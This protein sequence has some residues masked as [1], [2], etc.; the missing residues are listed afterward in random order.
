MI[1]QECGNKPAAL[2]F[3]KIVNGEKT[4]FHLC[5]SCAREKGDSIPGAPNG[6]SIH[7]LLSGI[8]EFEPS[9]GQ[10]V[11]QQKKVIRC[12]NCGLTYSQFRKIGRFGCSSCY[13]HF[14][15]PLNPLLKRV[16]GNS[17]HVGKIPK[18]SGGKIKYKRQIKDLKKELQSKID[19]EEFEEAAKLRDEIRSLE[20]KIS[21][22]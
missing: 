1:C 2:H 9:M 17:V 19:L 3:T 18:I 6:F 12:E 7:N 4:E 21:E 13:N 20:Q 10:N 11:K 14:S 16:H 15:D 8:L 5:E 22:A